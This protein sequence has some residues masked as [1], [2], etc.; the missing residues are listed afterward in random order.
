MSIA[1]P[2]FVKN[3]LIE[4]D[5]DIKTSIDSHLELL[6]NTP[7]NECKCDPE[8]GF[9]FNNMRFEVF[10][11]NEGVIL[12]SKKEKKDER[13][14]ELYNKKISGSSRNINTFATELKEV[15]NKYEK[16]LSDVNVV[17]SYV[18]EHKK[19]YIT[20]KGIIIKDQSNYQYSTT[21]NIWN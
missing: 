2:F 19:I 3:N 1:I 5:T 6:L 7:C 10:D 15:I 16:R 4:R 21:L 17:M 14:L 20:V 12:I 13:T 11:E 8:Y 9:V 18:R